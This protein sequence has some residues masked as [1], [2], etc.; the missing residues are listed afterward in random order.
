MRQVLEFRMTWLWILILESEP[1][2]ESMGAV[3]SIH[4][5]F[6]VAVCVFLLFLMVN[7]HL[8]LVSPNATLGLFLVW[9]SFFGGGHPNR[10]II[11]CGHFFSQRFET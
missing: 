8:L 10:D 7:Q 11:E 4:P 9:V 3:V 5:L 2:M 1:T 6:S